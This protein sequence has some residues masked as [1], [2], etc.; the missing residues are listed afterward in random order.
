M[1]SSLRGGEGRKAKSG[2]L[3]TALGQQGKKLHFCGCPA[4][5]HFIFIPPCGLGAHAAPRARRADPAPCPTASS[6]PHPHHPLPHLR[7][8]VGF[9][10][11]CFCLGWGS[12]LPRAPLPCEPPDRGVPGLLTAWAEEGSLL[13]PS[14][15]S[16]CRSGAS[17]SAPAGRRP[18]GGSGCPTAA[19]C[20]AG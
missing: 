2:F 5:S 3:L 20:S 13:S 12:P 7:G 15:G 10:L 9:V 19:D 1:N 8:L 17:T 16:R 18:R 6:S 11:G 4:F 14:P